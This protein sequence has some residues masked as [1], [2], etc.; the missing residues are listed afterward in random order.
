MLRVFINHLIAFWLTRIFSLFNSGKN[1]RRTLPNMTWLI[2]SWTWERG[3]TNPTSISSAW[4]T[5]TGLACGSSS[6]ILSICWFPGQDVWWFSFCYIV[7]CEVRKTIL[8]SQSLLELWTKKE[9]Y[10]S[11][12]MKVVCLLKHHFV[13]LWADLLYRKESGV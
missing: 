12:N 4:A 6:F 5:G 13:D 3:Y 1:L 9:K 10:M 2:P 11:L 7:F 8:L